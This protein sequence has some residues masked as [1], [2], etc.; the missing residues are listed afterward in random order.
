MDALKAKSRIGAESSALSM[1]STELTTKDRFSGQ[2]QAI[3][4]SC[5]KENGRYLVAI[6]EMLAE[7]AKEQDE[8][9][10]EC[11]EELTKSNNDVSVTNETTKSAKTDRIFTKQNHLENLYDIPDVPSIEKLKEKI[12]HQIKHTASPLYDLGLKFTC[13]SLQVKDAFLNVGSKYIQ[14]IK[15][16]SDKPELINRQLYKLKRIIGAYQMLNDPEGLSLYIHNI[17]IRSLIN[18]ETT[19]YRDTRNGAYYPFMIFSVSEKDTVMMLELNFITETIVLRVKDH[20]RKE[21]SFSQITNVLQGVEH[22]KFIIEF[23]FGKNK[24]RTFEATYQGQR[25]LII[26]CLLYASQIFAVTESPKYDI[27]KFQREN[28]EI[29][30]EIDQN[31]HYIR[32]PASD[33]STESRFQLMRVLMDDFQLPPKSL[34][35]AKVKKKNKKVGW[36]TR[37]CA[38]GLTHLLIARDEGFHK[39][40]NVVPLTAGTFAIKRNKDTITLRTSEREFI[41]KFENQKQT[42]SWFLNIVQ[43]TGRELI[44]FASETSKIKQHRDISSQMKKYLE[45][46]KEI[47]QT[48]I[49]LS[50]LN[51]QKE[52]LEKSLRKNYDFKE[53]TNSEYKLENYKDSIIK[54]SV[55]VITKIYEEISQLKN[56]KYTSAALQLQN[57]L[58]S[59]AS[60]N[61]INKKESSQVDK[62]SQGGKSDEKIDKYYPPN[63][64]NNYY[65]FKESDTEKLAVSME[66]LKQLKGNVPNN[67]YVSSK[68]KKRDKEKSLLTS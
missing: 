11:I 50:D 48:L 23:N 31:G 20:E 47:K 26:K 41:I 33:M 40:L 21:Y 59:V 32:E 64:S 44:D 16:N 35:K 18:Q 1:I 51:S 29:F 34:C 22:D 67:H 49:K 8:I 37:Y 60:K 39:L 56:V 14:I 57:K 7:I 63:L 10:I 46:E 2:R 66:M 38:L 42:E 65:I 36:E 30:G 52:E 58:E 62:E 4:A 61:N 25:D 17:R 6:Y 19:A 53:Y 54:D 28:S 5:K 12:I 15:E 55:K 3:K 68:K 13:T 43:L 9:T 24:I 45:V 27:L